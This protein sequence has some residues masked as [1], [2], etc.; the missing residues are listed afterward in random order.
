MRSRARQPIVGIIP[1]AG[2]ATR[3][4]DRAGSKELVTVGHA[5]IDGRPRAISEY[6]VEAM[7]HAQAD[8]ICMVIAPDKHDIMQFYGD[9]RR[10]GVPIGYACQERPTGMSDAIDIAYPW[11]QAATVLMGMPDTIVR[12]GHS[13]AAIRALLEESRC[14]IALAVAPTAEPARLGPVSVDRTG[15]VREVLDKPAAPPHNRVW[16]VA[17]WGPR[18]TGF[19]HD[20]LARH[21]RT[22]PEAPLGL[23]IQAAID[24]GFDVRARVFDDGCYID[25]GTAEGLAEARRL[26]DASADPVSR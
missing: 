10:H 15:R 23:L 6:L 14:D 18:F 19:L 5:R 12:P 1:A 4:P 24:D 25:A 8:R 13:L 7:V 2:R 26:L 20:R 21:P 22:L 17:C 11:L 9:G 16:T 3:L